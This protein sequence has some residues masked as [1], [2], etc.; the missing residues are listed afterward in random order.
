MLTK[1]SVKVLSFDFFKENFTQLLP[2]VVHLLADDQQTY[3]Y[4]EE[5]QD[6]ARLFSPGTTLDHECLVSVDSGY[7]KVSMHADR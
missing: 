4:F 1:L 2:Q 5:Q 3:C 7:P 6:G